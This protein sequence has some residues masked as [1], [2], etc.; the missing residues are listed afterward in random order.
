MAGTRWTKEQL[1]HHPRFKSLVGLDGCRPHAAVK[2]IFTVSNLRAK[3]AGPKLCSFVLK[4][5]PMGKPRMTQRDKWQKRPAVLRYRKYCD[6]LRE[7]AFAAGL[8]H[9][10][11]VYGLMVTAFCAMPQSWSEAKK[12]ATDGQ[13]HQ[14]KPDWD[15]IGKAVSDALF[16]E[17]SIVAFAAVLKYWCREGQER[18]EVSVL[19]NG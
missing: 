7:V 19:Y 17:D 12:R 16:E 5:P 18:T 9:V 2:I 3:H 4:G 8:D 10:K 14:Q 6:E 1:V 11:N 15:N 13:I